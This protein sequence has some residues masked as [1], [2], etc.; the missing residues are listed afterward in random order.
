MFERCV[1]REESYVESRGVVL[2]INSTCPREVYL[3][4]P[5]GRVIKDFYEREIRTYSVRRY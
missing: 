3:G 1:K 5:S 2:G 4:R